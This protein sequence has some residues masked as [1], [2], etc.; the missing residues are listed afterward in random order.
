MIIE[1]LR[2]RGKAGQTEKY[3]P[4]CKLTLPLDS[5]WQ[6]SSHWDGLH[7][8]CITCA[9]A[10]RRRMRNER[11]EARQAITNAGAAAIQAARDWDEG[12]RLLVSAWARFIEIDTTVRV[13]KHAA[14]V[15]EI[16]GRMDARLLHQRA[17]FS[18]NLA[19]SDARYPLPFSVLR[20]AGLPATLTE[21]IGDDFTSD[22]EDQLD[23]IA[24]GK[25]TY[26]MTLSDFYKPFH[27][28]VEEKENIGRE[29][30]K[31]RGKNA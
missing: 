1:P 7:T 26:E 6:D 22:M 18:L 17:S 12:I 24:E 2:F 30:E 21:Y 5:Y 20:E 31:L 29:L 11:R 19:L 14:G 25:R 3:C 15:S 8:Y 16:D 28:A 23:D 4:E 10:R 9:N 27:K 13:A